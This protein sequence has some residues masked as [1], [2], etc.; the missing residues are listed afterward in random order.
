MPRFEESITI[1]R[2]PEDVFDFVTDVENDP[3]WQSSTV[4]AEWLD[5][6]EQRVGRRARSLVRFLG[7]RMEFVGE[8]SEWNPP[9]Q[10]AFKTT[11]GPFMYE[12]QYRC[13]PEDGGCHLTLVGESP[14]LGGLFGKLADPVVVKM[15]A[16]QVRSDLANLK[17][18]LEAQAE[19]DL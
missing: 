12:G 6:G 8:T 10:A 1:N 19:R 13:E 11:E 14:T 7:K 4:E 16:R 5:E 9:K 3:L 15:Y 18:I 17:D 2:T